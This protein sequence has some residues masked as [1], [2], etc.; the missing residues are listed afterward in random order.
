MVAALATAACATPRTP[1]SLSKELVTSTGE[2]AWEPSLAIDPTNPDRMIVGA[3]YGTPAGRPGAKGIWIWRTTD[4]G[5]TWTSEPLDP[6]HLTGQPVPT[7]GADVIVGYAADGARLIAS[8]ADAS[9]DPGG[10]Y[11]SRGA[12]ETGPLTAVEP[13]RNSADSVTGMQMLFDKPWMV[14]DHGKKSPY[15]GSIY[16]INSGLVMDPGPIG[17]GLGWKGPM[18]SRLML[19]ASRDSGRS[20]SPPILVADSAFGATLAVGPDGALGMA[21]VALRN[22]QGGGDSIVFRRSLDGGVTIGPPEPIGVM[23]ADTVAELPVLA[24]RPNGEFLSC[25]AQGIRKEGQGNQVRCA[26]RS[27][28][29]GWRPIRGL[30]SLFGAGITP[31]WP[32]VAGSERGW[33]LMVY[34]ARADRVGLALFGS[35]DGLTFDQLVAPTWAGVAADRFCLARGALGAC[36]R[37]DV[38]SIGE[39]TALTASGGKL[40]MAYVLPA[41]ARRWGVPTVYVSIRPEQGSWSRQAREQVD[42]AVDRLLARLLKRRSR[43]STHPDSESP[44]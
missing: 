23:T 37:P 27:T 31:A 4:G 35:R 33:Y 34:L 15:R 1:E 30:D 44:R 16:L 39:Y 12:G 25:W 32:A 14:V 20:F 43:D 22:K 18:Q 3:M 5:Q 40:A 17:I 24:S 11:V 2:K 36:T 6:P 42:Y 28:E 9:P 26:I 19:S 13:Y 41:Q 38:F 21:Y 8:M 10:T 7:A 29:G